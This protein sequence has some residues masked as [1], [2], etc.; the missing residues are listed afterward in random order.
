VPRK[1]LETVAGIEPTLLEHPPVVLADLSTAIGTASA[2]LGA[3]LHPRTAANRRAVSSTSLAD[4]LLGSETP[5]GAVSLWLPDTALDALVPHLF[6]R[7][8]T[9]LV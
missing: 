7:R 1:A 3:R 9:C 2:T 5:K 6:G 8:S 4:G